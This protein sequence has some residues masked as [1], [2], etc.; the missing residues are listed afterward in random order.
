MKP[1][2]FALILPMASS[3]A[4][5]DPSDSIAPA[6]AFTDFWTST[7]CDEMKALSEWPKLVATMGSTDKELCQSLI[8][9]HQFVQKVDVTDVQPLPGNKARIKAN[10]TLISAKSMKQ[11]E[12]FALIDG[13][14]L[15][16]PK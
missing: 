6:K 16:T 14:W 2:A 15:L 13:K 1:F 9:M 7:D 8:G 10:I 5:A 3:L 11:E 4:Y 12:T